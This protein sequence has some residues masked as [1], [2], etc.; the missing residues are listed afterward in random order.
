MSC[1]ETVRVETIPHRQYCE[2]KERFEK[3]YVLIDS[4]EVHLDTLYPLTGNIGDIIERSRNFLQKSLKPASL[5]S[6]RYKLKRNIKYKSEN[7]LKNTGL[8]A[9]HLHFRLSDRSWSL[10]GVLC[11]CTPLDSA[12]TNRDSASEVNVST[13]SQRTKHVRKGVLKISASVCDSGINSRIGPINA[14][15]Y[16]CDTTRRSAEAPHRTATHRTAGVGI[17]LRRIASSH[18]H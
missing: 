9:N 12:L 3:N 10:S 8:Q 17:V 6:S 4:R 14:Q 13:G 2:P 15:R 16:P 18:A 7:Y 5:D 11:I 1:W